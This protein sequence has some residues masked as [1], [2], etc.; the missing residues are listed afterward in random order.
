MGTRQSFNAAATSGRVGGIVGCPCADWSNTP[1]Q[2]E[3]RESEKWRRWESNPRDVPAVLEAVS[4]ARSAVAC[5]VDSSSLTLLRDVV[6][7]CRGV[8]RWWSDCVQARLSGTPSAES[9]PQA[10]KRAA[11]SPLEP[12]AACAPPVPAVSASLRKRSASSF[13]PAALALSATPL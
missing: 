2:Q 3:S 1:P 12:A 13:R 8:G 9:A 6:A 11:K 7:G 4:C 5:G 10:W